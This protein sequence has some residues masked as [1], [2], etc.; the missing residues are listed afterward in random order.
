MVHLITFSLSFSCFDLYDE[1]NKVLWNSSCFFCG[2]TL[3]CIDLIQNIISYC[4]ILLY[5]VNK[6]LELVIFACL[7]FTA[8]ILIYLLFIIFGFTWDLMTIFPMFDWFFWRYWMISFRYSYIWSVKKFN[9]FDIKFTIISIG[10][11]V[12]VT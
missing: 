7:T 5:F 2:F 11:C 6:F 1:S 8:N 9:I 12:T 10:E 3:R 4:K